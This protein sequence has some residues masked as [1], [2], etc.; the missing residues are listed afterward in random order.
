MT[1]PQDTDGPR[2]PDPAA[3]A[4]L[5]EEV[6]RLRALNAEWSMQVTRDSA[7]RRK[8]EAALA[9][10]TEDRDLWKDAHDDDC[11]YRDELRAH[12]NDLG[13][14]LL[15]I[16]DAV[17]DPKMDAVKAVAAL[18]EERDALAD[19]LEDHLCVAPCNYCAALAR[20]GRGAE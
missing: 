9:A 5:V 11:P 8:A 10:M 16:A 13:E 20:A 19:A 2:T 14:I 17:G 7:M 3:H 6:E 15:A 4:A 12:M 1:R 18:R